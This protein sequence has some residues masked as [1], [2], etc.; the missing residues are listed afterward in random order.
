MPDYSRSE[1]VD[2]LLILGECRRNYN[3][4]AQLY[5]RRFPNRNH[6]P[7]RSTI[8]RIEQRERRGPQRSRQRRRVMTI[9]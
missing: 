7:S 1:I 4:A 2:I 8:Q 9:E 5:R 3:A 6:H